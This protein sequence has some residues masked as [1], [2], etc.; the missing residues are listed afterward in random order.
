MG[1]QNIPIYPK[2]S[3]LV[4]LI[5][6]IIDVAGSYSRGILYRF[7][8]QLGERYAQGLSDEGMVEGDVLTPIMGMLKVSGWFT[9]Y[10]LSRE[11]KSL[12]ITVTDAF[13]SQSREKGCDFFRGFL[14]GIAAVFPDLPT[15]YEEEKKEGC[16]TFTGK[17]EEERA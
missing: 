16:L 15:F 3:D 2:P 5:D 6:A 4:L 17:I 12:K 11:E 13:E 8:T 10:R 9:D 7:G 14:A 1:P